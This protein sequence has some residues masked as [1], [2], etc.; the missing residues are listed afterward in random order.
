MITLIAPVGD[1]AVALRSVAC[2]SRAGSSPSSKGWILAFVVGLAGMFANANLLAGEIARTFSE[3]GPFRAASVWT[4]LVATGLLLV[5]YVGVA[6]IAV[7]GADVLGLD[8]RGPATALV[9]APMA[10]MFC[11]E[12]RF[13]V[14]SGTTAKPR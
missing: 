4:W 6:L 9:F 14:W 10:T 12:C 3:P 13:K 7:V 2:R 8:G 1:T 11:N 5:V